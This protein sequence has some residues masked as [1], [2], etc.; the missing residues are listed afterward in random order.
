MLS[1]QVR[2]KVLARRGETQQAERFAREAIALA[3]GTDQP[4]Q[5]G[6]AYAD[7]GEVLAL[8]GRAY[9]ATTA[10]EQARACYER[11]GNFAST[12]RTQKRLA[13]L[14]APTA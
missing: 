6:D 11:K 9:E 7:L 13:A 10:L 4:S 14:Q 12:Q 3:E 8:A 2:A 5:Q 1:R